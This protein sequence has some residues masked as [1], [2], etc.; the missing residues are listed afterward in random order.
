MNRRSTL[1]IALAVMLTPLNP[2]AAAPA[3]ASETPCSQSQ[4]AQIPARASTALTG[5]Q[6]AP[7]LTGIDDDERETVIREQ[8][9]A[10]NIPSFL[11]QLR[12]VVLQ[13]AG[14]E[15]ASTQ[16]TVCV[17]PDYLALGSDD[18]FL[19][20]PMRL[21]TAL[22]VAQRYGF[23]LPTTKLVD[24]IYAQS[25]VHLN[26]QPLPASAA[27]RTTAYYEHHNQIV[28]GQRALLNAM[29]GLLTSGDKKDLVLTNRLWQNLERVAI[30]GWH[31]QDGKPIQPLSTVHGWHY[32]DYSHG[33]RFVSTDI[34]VDSR[35]QTL[36]SALENPLLA[37][38]LSSEGTLRGVIE[39]VDR[40]R[41]PH[42]AA[43]AN[44]LPESV[45]PA[46]PLVLMH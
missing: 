15:G 42:P 38:L 36:F 40:L 22:V 5:S 25:A 19:L 2:W 37:H 35:R 14:G 34:L 3:R 23:T 17:M 46:S 41:Q 33:V 43:L 31:R 30:Y 24:A 13:D 26:P 39:L 6:I 29:S 4:T 44:L 7:R 18:D 27:M 9:L 8:L 28:R 16:I 10:G 45:R 12:P 32:A 1:G 20:I 21:D 11:R